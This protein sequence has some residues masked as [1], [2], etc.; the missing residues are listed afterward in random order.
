MTS[1]RPL[2]SPD[3]IK[4]KESRAHG[5]L[6]HEPVPSMTLGNMRELG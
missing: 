2:R 1:A 5:V 4:G 6:R 3:W